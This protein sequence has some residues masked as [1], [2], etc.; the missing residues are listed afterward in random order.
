MSEEA[1]ELERLIKE[2]NVDELSKI[3]N[4]NKNLQNYFNSSNK[5]APFQPR[6]PLLLVAVK[7]KSQKVVEYL[8]SQDFVDKSVCNSMGENIYHVI[9]RKRGAEQLFSIIERNVPHHLLLDESD[10]EV[11]AFDIACKKNNISFVKRVHEILESLQLDFTPSK[12]IK[13]VRCTMHY[14]IK[15]LK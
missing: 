15:I 2:D 9:C 3:L 4:A 8:L 11:N 14:A 12:F 6:F 5:G 13:K 10:S 7:E 1:K